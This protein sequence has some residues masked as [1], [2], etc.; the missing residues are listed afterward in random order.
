MKVVFL[1][2]QPGVVVNIEG[3]FRSAGIEAVGVSTPEEALAV[4]EAGA[5]DAVFLRYDRSG[6]WTW[7]V[8]DALV[9]RFPELR[10][11]CFVEDPS[12]EEVEV[13]RAAGMIALL[14][15]PISLAA[16]SAVLA[17]QSQ[18]E[19]SMNTGADASGV[20]AAFKLVDLIQMCCISQK[21]ACL[22]VVDGDNEGAIY[23][24]G[25]TVAHAEIPGI[26]GEEAVYEMV[27]W[28]N[29]EVALE[30]G[31]GSP[32]LTVSSGW[33]HLLMEGARRRDERGDAAARDL[34]E[35]ALGEQLVGRMVGPFRVRKRLASDYWGTLYEATQVAVNRTVALKILQPGFYEDPRQVQQFVAFAAA[36]AG[37]QNPY[38]TSVYEAGE[39]SGLY[40]Y[41]R[42]HLDGANLH[43][44][45]QQRQVLNEDLALRVLLNVSEALNYEKKNG[46][47]HTPLSVEQVLIPNVGVPKL[48]NN[49]TMEGGEVSAGEVDEMRRLGKIIREAMEGASET[50]EEFQVLLGKMESA[51]EGGFADW[52]TLLHEGHQWDLK[53][54]A[55]HVVRPLAASQ[56]VVPEEKKVVQSWML[57]A[58]GGVVVLALAYMVF[59]YSVIRFKSGGANDVGAMV[60]VKGGEFEFQDKQVKSLPTFFIDKYE[61]TL[62]EYRKFLEAWKKDKTVVQEHPKARKNKEHMPTDWDLIWSEGVQKA[63]PYRGVRIFEN[64]PVFGVDYFDAWAYAKWAGK[65]LPTEM[66]WEK[67]ARGPK[68]NLFP[69]GNDFEAQRANTGGDLAGGPDNPASGRT[70]GFSLW[71]P[72]GSVRGDRS[73]YGAMDMAGNVSEWTDS[74]DA[75]ADFPSEQVPVVR[76]GSWTTPDVRL[77]LRD[78]HN[79]E[80]QRNRQI[81][82]RCASDKPPA[83]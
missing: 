45:L 5:C 1:E 33:E 34:R 68:G 52:D 28:D 13:V 61:V 15:L 78:L 11:G 17:S 47:L 19:P 42:E 65:R 12:P 66:E 49:V 4:L 57:W 32:K 37:A 2:P 60:E 81:G 64:T 72:V 6:E 76:G 69:W 43:E 23:I 77:T 29:S 44:R 59:W 70:D 20:A 39:G 30:E 24:H 14:P 82:F 46:I 25:G 53:R 38:I 83:K 54:R 56:V 21:T 27:G 67:A 79:P 31:V 8:R 50:S 75:M 63:R 55:M 74:F 73:H 71:A 40:F 3:D 36:M 48:L 62:G 9:A 16:V 18:A 26:E 10:V 41:A 80:L 35:E 22:R 58:L 7:P 51:G